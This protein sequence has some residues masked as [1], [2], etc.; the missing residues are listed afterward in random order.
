M[1]TNEEYVARQ[2]VI[3]PKCGYSD[4]SGLGVDID[5]GRASQRVFCQNPEC[6]FEWQD[7]YDLVGYTSLE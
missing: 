2:G 7:W 6:D 1:L 4:V 5:A 3:C